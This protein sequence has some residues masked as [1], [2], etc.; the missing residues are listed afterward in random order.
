M[1]KVARI[2]SLAAVAALI[3]AGSMFSLAEEPAGGQQA[4]T[5]V[6][7]A[8]PPGTIETS[9]ANEI[10]A[11][12]NRGIDWLVAQQNENGSWS[13]T[14]FPALTALALQAVLHGEHPKKKEVVDKAVRFI[15]SCVQKDGGIY[16]EVAGRKGGGL[17]NYNT[18][19][20]MTAL[21]EVGDPALN[22]VIQDA[23]KFVAGAQYMGDDVYK[24]GFGYDKDTQRA[25]TDL[26]NT[27]YSVEA[28]K[29]TADVEDSRPNTE[30]KADI[31]WNE[32]VKFLE[33]MQN[34]AESGDENAGGFYYNPTDPKAGTSTNKTGVVVF[35]SFG[36]ITYAGMLALIHANVSRDDV[37]V[38]SA[39]EWA[40]RHWSLDENPGMGA[41]GVYFFYDILAKCLSAY[42]QDLVPVKDKAPIN[43]KA[44]LA[45]KLVSLQKI[46]DKTGHGFWKNDVNR[47]WE[48]NAVLVTAYTLRALEAVAK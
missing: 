3:L 21:H 31:D 41:Q 37:R 30:K 34:K 11:S 8:Q 28:M 1:T 12:I 2:T 23:R 29:L 32:T 17:S 15:L 25:Y 44:E 36:S 18:A 45:K 10:R 33:K 22:K 46:E 27:Y 14:N 16:K 26:L 19:I 43:W 7:S 20:C 40:A 5:M 39:F 38:K 4:A 9:V 6:S 47:Y 24:G 42:G 13:D 35:R 48:D